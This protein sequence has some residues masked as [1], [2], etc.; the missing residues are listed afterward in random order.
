MTETRKNLN[1]A[2]TVVH[3]AIEKTGATDQ[4]KD[5]MHDALERGQQLVDLLFGARSRWKTRKKS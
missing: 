4:A 2:A 3:H 1:R 5:E